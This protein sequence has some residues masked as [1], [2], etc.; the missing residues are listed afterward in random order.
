[1]EHSSTTFCDKTVS[2]G[3]QNRICGSELSEMWKINEN[4]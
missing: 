3:K 2:E 1:M 4:V